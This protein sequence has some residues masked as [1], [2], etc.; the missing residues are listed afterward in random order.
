MRRAARLR[1]GPGR[2]VRRLERL[3]DRHVRRGHADV[4]PHRARRRRRRRPRRPLRPQARLRRHEPEREQLAR[5][6]LRQSHRR[7]LQRSDRRDAVLVS[8][9]RHL[10]DG[11]VDHGRR[12]VP[13]LH[14]RDEAGLRDDLRA[15]HAERA[16]HRRCD[17]G[18]SR[19]SAR[20]P[21]ARVGRQPHCDR[22]RDHLRR[23][24]AAALLRESR[25]ERR[26]LDRPQHH[27]RRD[28]L[29]DR[30]DLRRVAGEPRRR[31]PGR[32]ARPDERRLQRA[33]ADHAKHA[34]RGVARRREARRAH[35]SE[36]HV[37]DRRP[38]L[39]VHAGVDARREDLRLDD[40]RHRQSDPEPARRRV[41]RY[42]RRDRVQ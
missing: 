42:Q 24:R 15:Q 31:L 25:P 1:A 34:C 36:L 38:H 3:H 17:Q 11:A 28:H 27:G 41:H 2:D 35:R 21:R 30:H 19:R 10:R 5:R 37:D 7:Q 22:A 18:P 14:R 4:H 29:R 33:A 12:L 16:G 13:P 32:D 26:P 8:R 9:Q 6:N 40:D 39:F 20:R 23:D